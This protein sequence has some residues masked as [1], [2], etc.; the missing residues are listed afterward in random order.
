MYFNIAAFYLQVDN[1]FG[2]FLLFPWYP[3]PFSWA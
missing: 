1:V 3:V 2:L